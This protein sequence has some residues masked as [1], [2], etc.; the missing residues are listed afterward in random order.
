MN[1]PCGSGWLGGRY[2][3]A[4]MKR[5]TERTVREFPQAASGVIWFAQ[6]SFRVYT[7][8]RETGFLERFM[9]GRIVIFM[10]LLSLALVSCGD[11][12]SDTG[13]PPLPR[14]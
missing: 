13:P 9:T 11:G 1:C 12:I 8:S 2:G 14:S 10:L 6:L 5:G 4:S 3:R 7:D